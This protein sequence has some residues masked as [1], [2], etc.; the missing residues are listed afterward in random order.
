MELIP[1]YYIIPNCDLYFVY[2]FVD[3]SKSLRS[4]PDISSSLP[5]ELADDG[6]SEEFIVFSDE[7]ITYAL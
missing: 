1:Q 4:S 7:I 6:S 3:F 2:I 5:I